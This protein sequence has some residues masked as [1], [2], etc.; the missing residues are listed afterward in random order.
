M[1]KKSHPIA[2]LGWPPAL[3][4]QISKAGVVALEELTAFSHTDIREMFPIAHDFMALILT[5]L[6]RHGLALPK[7][8]YNRFRRW[9]NVDW[10]LP[11]EIIAEQMQTTG[12]DVSIRRSI[13]QY[14]RSGHCPDA[15]HTWTQR[16]S[17]SA[18]K[19]RQLRR[20]RG[21]TQEQ[22]RHWLGLSRHTITRLE[23]GH[24]EP[25]GETLLRLLLLFNVHPRE[26]S[27]RDEA[28]HDVKESK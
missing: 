14:G 20:S 6:R 3:E 5:D 2:A 12:H 11:N 1:P 4:E 18:E 13:Y 27:N 28:T 23:N 15:N 9:G 24:T 19:L 21:Y 16:Y 22:L 10:G 7:R 26:I 25:T 8:K 17:F